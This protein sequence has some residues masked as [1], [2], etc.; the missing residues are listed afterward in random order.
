MRLTPAKLFFLII[1]PALFTAAGCVSVD[2]SIPLDGRYVTASL[3]PK[4]FEVIGPV[5]VSS[6]EVHRAGPF[7]M[8]KSV[9]GSKVTYSD[10]LE[11]AAKL[12]ADNIIDVRIDIHSGKKARFAE[13]LTG[14]ERTFTYS[15]EALAIKYVGQSGDYQDAG[16]FRR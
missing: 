11:E 14:W 12:E 7:G 4:D 6:V 13:N 8:V 9:N 10:L 16:F 1:L 5:L 15:G 2:Y 3:A